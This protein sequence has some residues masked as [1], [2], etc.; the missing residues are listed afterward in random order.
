MDENKSFIEK[1]EFE[2]KR[3]WNRT[4][5]WCRRKVEWVKENPQEA[6][7]LGGIAVAGLTG[8]T[9]VIKAVKPTQQEIE[10]DR[11]DRSYYDRHTGIRWELRRKMTNQE[12]YELDMR[13]QSGE[14]VRDILADMR[15]I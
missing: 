8:L 15:L 11:I 14:P 7:M 13:M 3:A 5:A 4:T 12:R 2:A 1:V 6:V 10:R 9:K